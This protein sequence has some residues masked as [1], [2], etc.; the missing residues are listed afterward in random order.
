MFI[1]FYMFQFHFYIARIVRIFKS[2]TNK[3]KS[4]SP[5][6]SR[7]TSSPSSDSSHRSLAY[8]NYFACNKHVTNTSDNDD[9]DDDDDDDDNIDAWRRQWYCFR[10]KATFTFLR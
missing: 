1:D 4:K 7:P 2:L 3:S 5:S 8:W 10:H 6:P 9:Y